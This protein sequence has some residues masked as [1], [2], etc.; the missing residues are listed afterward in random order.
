MKENKE[1]EFED[2]MEIVDFSMQEVE[3]I[4]PTKDKKKI[5]VKLEWLKNG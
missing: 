4:I 5:T 1:G 2:R 3:Y